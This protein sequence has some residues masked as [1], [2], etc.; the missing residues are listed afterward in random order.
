MIPIDFQLK[1]FYDLSHDELYATMVLRQEIFVVEQDCVYLDADD[2]DQKSFHLLGNSAD[3][4]LLAYTRL[5][6]KGLIYKDYCAIGRVIVSKKI[7][8]QNSGKD[9][10]NESIQHCKI[11]FPEVDIRIS[12][13]SYLLKFY[14]GLG[15]EVVGDEYLE[16]G[17]PHHAMILKV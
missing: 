8:G 17:I 15:F 6:P 4:L 9:L 2:L 1:S 5:V 13:Q 7:R 11:L 12:A 10:M 14:G 16:D 3:G